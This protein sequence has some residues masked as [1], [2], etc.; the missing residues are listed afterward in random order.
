MAREELEAG[1]SSPLFNAER[2]EVGRGKELKQ[3]NESF[4]QL[5]YFIRCSRR[6]NLAVA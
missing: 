1:E 2:L 3:N 5:C 4:L 6:N